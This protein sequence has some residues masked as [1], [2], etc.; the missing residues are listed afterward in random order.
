M[1]RIHEAPLSPDGWSRALPSIAA[2][3]GSQLVNF[4]IDDARG[5]V[6]F[7]AAFGADHDIAARFRAAG[8]GGILP[9]WW[10]TVPP[11]TPTRTSTMW[12][13]RRLLLTAFYEEVVK[14]TRTYYGLHTALPCAAGRRAHLIVA[15]VLGRAD[16]APE[17]I[18][19]MQMLIPHVMTTLHVSERLAAADLCAAGACA[20]LGRVDAG[21]ILVDAAARVLFA[22]RVAEGMLSGNNGLGI[23][24]DGLRAADQGAAQ[25][26]RR[27]IAGC[28][29]DTADALA[30]GGLGG[31]V[32]VPGREG[33]A[34]LRIAVAPFPS[35]A[36]HLHLAWLGRAR[37]VAILMIVTS[38]REQHEPRESLRHRFGLTAA[39]ADLAQEIVM[40]D[41]RQAAAAR[42]G[43]SLATARTH[44]ERIFEK[45]GVHRQA[46]LVR[47][48]LQSR[49]G[50]T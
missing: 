46:E 27:L 44:L 3:S 11:G 18:A 42:L 40:G 2:A 6:E 43:I 20:A 31:P 14:P 48:L 38:G 16:Y 25:V 12:P 32:E 5:A 34:P 17:E 37:P 15:R 24:K 13:S 1:Q 36:E 49:S 10:Q 35:K 4:H 41:G 45:T 28:A 47:L 33:H 8:E 9:R 26:L 30:G 21:V 29:A 22:N 39:E 50:T 7:H 19:S 23:G